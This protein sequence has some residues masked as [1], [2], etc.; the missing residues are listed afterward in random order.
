MVLAE[1]ERGTRGVKSIARRT[2]LARNTVR[3]ILRAVE[4]FPLGD[5][6]YEC[7]NGD[8]YQGQRAQV[9]A[10]FLGK[11]RP[12]PSA[13]IGHGTNAGYVLEQKRGMPFCDACSAAHS[14]YGKKYRQRRKGE[15]R[16]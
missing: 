14:E 13:S 2:G 11:H 1:L 10:H 3:R 15:G 16:R 9:H 8:G 4:T 6:L 12:S 7:A 5:G